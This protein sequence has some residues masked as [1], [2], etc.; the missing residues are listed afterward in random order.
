MSENVCEKTRVNGLNG[1]TRGNGLPT[2]AWEANP[3]SAGEKE[4]K[5]MVDVK[6]KILEILNNAFR[7]PR[8]YGYSLRLLFYGEPNVTWVPVDYPPGLE[9]VRY[10]PYVV[11]VSITPLGGKLR[12]EISGSVYFF[13]TWKQAFDYVAEKV[14]ELCNYSIVRAEIVYVT[15]DVIW[16]RD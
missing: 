3:E 2:P 11:C 12:V 5:A 4:K 16:R 8:Y 10:Y 6:E 7:D 1:G 15:S 13:E 9:K 14:A